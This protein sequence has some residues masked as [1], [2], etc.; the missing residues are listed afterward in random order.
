MPIYEYQCEDC[1]THFELRQGYGYD[2]GALSQ[3][4]GP[5]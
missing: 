4:S 5:G 2:G 3:V 1:A